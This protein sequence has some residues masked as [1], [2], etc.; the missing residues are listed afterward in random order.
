MIGRCTKDGISEPDTLLYAQ[1]KFQDGIWS[2]SRVFEHYD[3]LD[4]TKKA[5]MAHKKSMRWK[6]LGFKKFFATGVDAAKVC[7]YVITSFWCCDFACG[8]CEKNS[9]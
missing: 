6:I 9:T 4:E 2:I 5:S 8:F 1:S 3:P 7:G